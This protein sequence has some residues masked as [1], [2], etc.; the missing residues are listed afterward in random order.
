MARI[1]VNL[2]SRETTPNFLF[3]KEMI[4]LGDELLFITSKIFEERIQWIKEALDDKNCRIKLVVLPEG[5]EEKW[6]Q[7]INLIKK[8]LSKDHKYL[9]NLTCGTKYMISAVPKA[10]EKFDADF[11]YIPFPKNIILKI[12]EETSIEIKY[13]MTVKEYFDCNNTQIPKIKQLTK[14]KEYTDSF[15]TKFTT[16]KLNF[17]ILEKIRI[18]YREKRIN[19]NEV[20]NKT[21]EE[22]SPKS[23]DYL[24]FCLKSTS[25]KQKQV[26]YRKTKPFF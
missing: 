22:R 6:S 9:V 24:I 14:P 17:D 12:G 16:E 4:K 11:F 2:V 3:I 18:G 26:F 13:R 19:I 1:L 15:F 20:E 25:L 23:P 10:F 21:D 8:H 7:M 5:A